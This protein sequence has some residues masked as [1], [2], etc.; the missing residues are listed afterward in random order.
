MDKL[1]PTA[2]FEPHKW[3]GLFRIAGFAALI[4]VVLIPIQIVVFMLW[5]PPATVVGW[6][7][8]F[9]KSDIVGLLDMDLLLMVDQVLTGMILVALYVALRKASSSVTTVAVAL[10]LSG[11]IIYFSS[12]VAFEMMSLSRLYAAAGS[13]SERSIL[14]AAGQTMLVTWQ[15]TAFDVSYVLEGIS[16]LLIATVMLRSA[17]FGRITGWVGV[18]LGVMSLVPPTV[19]VVGMYFAFVSLL[20]LVTWDILICR[21]F[22]R[23]ANL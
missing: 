9:H 16:I 13:E 20:P 12:T 14:L 21:K 11:M 3:D 19:A 15:G 4:M 5:P 23:L 6:F 18:V 22:F 2:A 17:V 1:G 8:L 7:E 10:G